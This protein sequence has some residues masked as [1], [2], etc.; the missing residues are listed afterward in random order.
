M[1]VENDRQKG[2][3]DTTDCLEAVNVFRGWKNLLFI[4]ILLSLLTIQ[5]SFWAT[6]LDLVKE[7]PPQDQQQIE[8]TTDQPEPSKEIKD[9]AAQIEQ[10]ATEVTSDANILVIEKPAKK[11]IN[12]SITLRPAHVLWAIRSANFLI[13]L[14]ATL[15]CLTILFCLKIS[16]IGRLGGIN[17]I[18]R[19]FFLSLIMLVLIL[20]WQQFLGWFVAGAVFEP[21]EL[22]T[23]FQNYAIE[24]TLG[25]IWY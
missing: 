2:L 10:A 11:S 6:D 7:H 15:Y 17:H 22:M 16:L 8:I 21:S 24:S 1:N 20:P 3:V 25:K 14:A 18:C 12:F 5:L 13:I 23:H 4:I 19:A 9:E